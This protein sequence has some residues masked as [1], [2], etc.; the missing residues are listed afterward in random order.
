V[1]PRVATAVDVGRGAYVAHE[2]ASPPR[3]I[4]M[5]TG[6]EVGVAMSAAAE[7]DAAGLPTRVV[8]MP[9]WELFAAQP[10]EYR[11][12]V[13]PPAIRVRVAIEAASPFGWERWVGDHGHIIAMR[14]FGASAPAERLFTEFGITPA[15]A[16]AAVRDLLTR[17]N[18]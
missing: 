16:A 8:S 11:D 6:S 18:A 2:P 14:S 7:L 15:A 3:A 13:L 17:S 9:S 5:A 10:R 1:L 4:L 12:Q